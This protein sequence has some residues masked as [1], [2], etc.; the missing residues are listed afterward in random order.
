[1]TVGICTFELV[2]P[3]ARSLKEKRQALRGLIDRLRHRHNVSVAEVAHQDLWQRAGVAVAAV[4]SSQ[5]TIDRM[6]EGI[7]REI[8]LSFPGQV[9]RH[10]VEYV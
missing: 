3:G 10:E 6:F 1:V 8:E 7:L 9:T 4:S 2:I 5:K